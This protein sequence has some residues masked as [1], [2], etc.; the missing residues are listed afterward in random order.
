MLFDHLSTICCLTTFCHIHD[1]YGTPSCFPFLSC[2]LTSSVYFFSFSPSLAVS[3]RFPHG[4]LFFSLVRLVF[5]VSPF[6]N[7]L[8]VSLIS[9]VFLFVAR[10]ALRGH[11][12]KRIC[13]SE[14]SAEWPRSIKHTRPWRPPLSL[15]VKGPRLLMSF[16]RK[17]MDPPQHAFRLEQRH[18][19]MELSNKLSRPT[20]SPSTHRSCYFHRRDAAVCKHS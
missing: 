16:S 15:H 3:F 11:A 2:S 4:I 7:F 12:R 13:N 5:P 1:V 8:Y 9:F 10:F 18:S 6:P 20:A 19:E 17:T 14:S